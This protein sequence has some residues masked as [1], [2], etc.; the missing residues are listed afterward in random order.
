MPDFVLTVRR[1]G[2]M[3]KFTMPPSFFLF[4]PVKTLT[5]KVAFLSVVKIP[6]LLP[7]SESC[8]DSYKPGCYTSKHLD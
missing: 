1:A 7:S 8:V 5:Y 3:R 2:P 6:Y 4:F